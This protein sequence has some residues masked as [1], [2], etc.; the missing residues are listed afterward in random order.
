MQDLKVPENLY[1]TGFIANV[2]DAGHTDK[3]FNLER[4]AKCRVIIREN[5]IKIKTYQTSSSY[6]LKDIVERFMGNYIS[7]GEFIV[8]MIA[9]GF[10]YKL[11]QKG[12]SCFFNLSKKSY[13]EMRAQV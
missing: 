13:N 10:T 2:V 9:E 6:H 8:A 12:P 7:N 3:N 5:F 11:E 4:I 1:V